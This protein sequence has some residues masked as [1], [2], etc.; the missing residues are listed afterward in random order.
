MGEIL[1]NKR[2]F[3][4]MFLFEHFFEQVF[5]F[6]KSNLHHHLTV[7][8]QCEEHRNYVKMNVAISHQTRAAQS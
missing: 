8:G 3:I 5:F 2:P 7:V 4:L 6:I 1:K